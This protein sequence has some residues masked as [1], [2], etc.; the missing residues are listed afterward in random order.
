MPKHILSKMAFDSGYES[1]ADAAGSGEL[2]TETL[3]L[4]YA[5]YPAIACGPRTQ[6]DGFGKVRNWVA[7][8]TVVRAQPETG[9]L[10][11]RPRQA[12]MDRLSLRCLECEPLAGRRS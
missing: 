5:L 2:L 9:R 7:A 12:K 1:G 3:D 11:F 8:I 6:P 10:T 4:R